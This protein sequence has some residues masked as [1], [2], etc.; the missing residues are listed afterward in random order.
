MA[1]ISS[2]PVS[3]PNLVDQVLGSNTYDST[4]TAVQGNPTVQY[5]FTSIKTLVDQQMVQQLV[6]TS[7]TNAT[8]PLIASQGPTATN[9]VY[10]ILFGAAQTPTLN[11]VKIDA[12]GKVTFVSTGTYYIKQEYYI[13][14]TLA[15]KPVL[16]FRTFKDEL[17][18]EGETTMFNLTSNGSN[19]RN[20][21]VI[22]NIVNI[23][24]GG[25]IYEF[26]MVR[27]AA[28]ANDG[29]LFKTLNNNAGFEDVPNASLTISKLV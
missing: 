13:G 17:T 3:I 7:Q 15:S 27:D 11:H 25:T 12:V 5:T 24:G 26:Q 9:N 1:I 16:L 10:T 14:A 8:A 20:R 4:G 28:G 2:Y 19:D 29:T 22:E 18:Q 6:A 23:T 21:L